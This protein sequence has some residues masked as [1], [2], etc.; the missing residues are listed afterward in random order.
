MQSNRDDVFITPEN[1]PLGGLAARVV[2]PTA[3]A[4]ATF[5]GTTR[6]NFEGKT[7]VK[8]EYEAYEPMAAKEIQKICEAVR[9]Q[10]PGVHKISIHHRLG[11]VKVKEASVVIA[12]SSPHRKESLEVRSDF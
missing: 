9:L 12:V 2:C 1:L 10:W 7:V 4:I 5:I 8:L 3:G 6:D 11:V